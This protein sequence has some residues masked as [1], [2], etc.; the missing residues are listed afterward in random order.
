MN[1]IRVLLFLLVSG[2][3]VCRAA[4]SDPQITPIV[5][6]V[7]CNGNLAT[8]C[9]LI[10]RQSGIVVGKELDDIQ[11]ENAR[12]RLEGLT[13]FRSVRIHLAKGSQKHW[14][15]VVIDV[16]EASP[17][18]TAYAAGALLQFPERAGQTG[19]LAARVTDYDLFGTGK[20]LDLALVAARPVGG[21]GDNDGGG[22]NEYAVRLEYRDPRLLGSHA[23]F[24]TAGAFYSQSSFYLT[25]FANPVY[26]FAS[27]PSAGASGS[28]VDFSVG[29]HLGEYS[30]VTAGYRYVVSSNGSGDDFLLSDGIFT[31]LNSTP[32]NVMLFTVGRNT[33]DDPS[34][35]THGWLLHAYDIWNPTAGGDKGGALIRGTWRAGD[36]AY[37]TFQTRPFDNYRSLFDDDLG[38]SLT[39]SRSLFSNSEAGARR[40]R[41]YVGPGAT[42][43][44]HVY[45]EH[46]FEI[47]AKAGV[48]LE[49]KYF[50]TVNFYIIATHPVHVGG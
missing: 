27:G 26:G 29:M 3:L 41:W 14:V 23:F 48:R 18:S 50:G 25:N 46:F 22:D 13:R 16:I 35:P 49:T 20:S 36:D 1:M 38:I 17:L 21:G 15:I 6:G 12:L 8:P 2:P 40:A 11:V 10:R 31:T 24:F 45:G 39:Y 9:E 42:N 44:G 19:V 30:Y 28:G 33:E 37:W 43:L 32:G 34:F 47:G 4:E 7:Q 5:E